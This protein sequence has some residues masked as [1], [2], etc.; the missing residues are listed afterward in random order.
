MYQYYCR[1]DISIHALVKRATCDF[2]TMN[3]Y[4]QH[5][6]PRPREKGDAFNAQ[7]QAWF[8]ISIHALVKRATP[9]DNNIGGT[10]N[11]SI[12]ALV[13]RATER[14]CKA[15][16]HDH[17]SIHALV[18]RATLKDAK[19]KYAEIYFNPR[20]REKGDSKFIQ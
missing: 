18:K 2:G 14:P 9:L 12:H 8:A 11:I 4:H 3:T 20:P 17:I 10:D 19:A 5:F 13:K 15:H 6:N 7:L 1:L 16:L